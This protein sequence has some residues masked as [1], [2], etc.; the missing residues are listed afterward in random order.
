[1]PRQR[2]HD[3]VISAQAAAQH[4][5]VTRRQ[6]LTSG[7]PATLIDDRV[8]TRQLVLLH[9]G[10]YALGH[11]Q[12]TAEGWWMAAVASYRPPA[13]LSHGSAATLWGLSE[14]G[15]RRPIHVTV[16]G[17][18]A[19]RRRP[20]VQPHRRAVLLEDEVTVVRGIPVTTVARTILD[21]A[22]SV[23]GRA[24]EQIIRRADRLQLFDRRDQVRV[25]DRHPRDRGAAELG[26]LLVALEGR[27]TADVR[28]RLEVAFAQLC[29]DH[30]LPRP[31]IN[32]IILGERVDFSWPATTLVIETDGFEF[33]AM[34]TTFAAD[35]RRDQK[36]TL[37]GYTVVRLTYDQVV[38]DP[39]KTA[40]T[41]SAL[42][43]QCRVR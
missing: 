29:D 2:T 1:M 16:G 19:A 3:A 24:L 25:L 27:G 8:R 41:V 21:V 18:A 12:L 15:L 38:G 40:A 7:V 13:A 42:L 26:R 20:G 43:T 35:R 17:R 22:A 30:G 10:V 28:S 31:R 33:H 36:L 11:A 32:A 14:G 23:R 5:V 6:L 37:A 4:G 9:R 39:V 34:P